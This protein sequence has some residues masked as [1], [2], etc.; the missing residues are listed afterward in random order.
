MAHLVLLPKFPSAKEMG[1]IVPLE[2]FRMHG[3]P[4]DIFSDRGPQFV[5]QFLGGILFS[6]GDLCQ[7]VIRFLP[8]SPTR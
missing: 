5:S 6:L 4:T 2:V 1:E 8:L 7:S 3:L